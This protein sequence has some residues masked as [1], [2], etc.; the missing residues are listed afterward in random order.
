M[1]ITSFL[2][3]KKIDRSVLGKK[4]LPFPSSSILRNHLINNLST[5]NASPPVKLFLFPVEFLINHFPTAAM[6]LHV[7]TPVKRR[8]EN[9]G[10]ILVIVN[11]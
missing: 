6:A 4:G 8:L 9:K 11:N 1:M 2:L 3:W 7:A 10:K 5:E